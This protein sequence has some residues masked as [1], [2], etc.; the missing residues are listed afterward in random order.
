MPTLLNEIASEIEQPSS[1][2]FA[3]DLTANWHPMMLDE[4]SLTLSEFE[5]TDLILEDI[6]AGLEVETLYNI[7]GR[8]A[9][10]SYNEY[11]Q[12]RLGQGV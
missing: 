10:R 2:F 6:R 3:G 5:D 1:R 8:T 4:T 7:H 12:Y 11:R 9:F